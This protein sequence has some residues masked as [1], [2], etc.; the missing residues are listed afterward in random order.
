MVQKLEVDA[1][2]SGPKNPLATPDGRSPGRKK[3]GEH[4]IFWSTDAVRDGWLAQHMPISPMRSI[5]QISSSA[6]YADSLTTESSRRLSM[7]SELRV[8]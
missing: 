1:H 8:P 3:T 7:P 2:S 5:T 4:L 6:H